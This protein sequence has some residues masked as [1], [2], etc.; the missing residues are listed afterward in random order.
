MK[1]ILVCKPWGS[2]FF[3]FCKRCIHGILTTFNRWQ[4]NRI[5]GSEYIH[6][7]STEKNHFWY[8]WGLSWQFLVPKY[9][10]IFLSIQSTTK[11]SLASTK[12][13]WYLHSRAPHFFHALSLLHR[14]GQ[15]NNFTLLNLCLS[16]QL[17]KPHL[18][19]PSVSLKILRKTRICYIELS[20]P[21]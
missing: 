1:S 15:I 13:K 19:T 8:F 9:N 20:L 3:C 18:L 16:R 4:T 7:R 6:Y 21:S 2:N 10:M 14:R 5:E 11:Y 17:I 12:L